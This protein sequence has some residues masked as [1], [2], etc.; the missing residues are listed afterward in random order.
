MLCDGVGGGG[1]GG[2]GGGSG[3]GGRGQLL[4][5]GVEGVAASSVAPGSPAN[6]DSVWKWI[7]KQHLVHIP[8]NLAVHSVA[9]PAHC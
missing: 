9:I 3:R 4:T 7:K 1:G 5:G 2:G 8:A 6:R